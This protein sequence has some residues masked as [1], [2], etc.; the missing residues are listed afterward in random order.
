[1]DFPELL[2]QLT[3][4]DALGQPVARRFFRQ[5]SV[6]AAAVSVSGVAPI[7]EPDTVLIVQCWGLQLRPGAAQNAQ[8]ARLV[9]LDTLTSVELLTFGGGTAPRLVAATETV[10]A[11]ACMMPVFSGESLG[12]VATFDAGVA[13]NQVIATFVGWAIPRGTLQR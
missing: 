4:K 1:M 8:S 5:I 3:I 7:T 13:S 2:Y 10:Y 11:G 9:L 12:V 6:A